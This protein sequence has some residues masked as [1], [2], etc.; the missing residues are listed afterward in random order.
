[1]TRTSARFDDARWE[2]WELLTWVHLLRFLATSELYSLR[3]AADTSSQLYLSQTR[4]V[5]ERRS[6]LYV[7]Q[8]APQVNK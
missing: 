1:M 5:R 3:V 2:D 8:R 4:H 7:L 6:E